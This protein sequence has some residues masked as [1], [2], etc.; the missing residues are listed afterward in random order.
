VQADG[1]GFELVELVRDGFALRMRGPLERFF[2]A[3]A[4]GEDDHELAVKR[5]SIGSEG[6]DGARELS[7]RVQGQ[8]R[9]LQIQLSRGAALRSYAFELALPAQEPLPAA[10]HP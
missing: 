3:R 9:R 10:P 6:A 4:F 8:P 2:S 5:I 7:F 1:L